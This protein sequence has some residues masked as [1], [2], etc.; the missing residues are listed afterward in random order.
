MTNS[1]T[2]IHK[3]HV[4]T[5]MGDYVCKLYRHRDG[6]V[7]GGLGDELVNAFKDKTDK[8][9]RLGELKIFQAIASIG[10]YEFTERTH[11]DAEYVYHIYDKNG[12]GKIT[13]TYQQWFDE[14]EILKGKENILYYSGEIEDENNKKK[15]QEL[16]KKL[17]EEYPEKLDKVINTMQNILDYWQ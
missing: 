8:Y 14:E 5:P 1:V 16:A 3:K 17:A 11:S 12:D 10:S 4:T 9:G 7:K 6:Y 15:V 13:I 2:F